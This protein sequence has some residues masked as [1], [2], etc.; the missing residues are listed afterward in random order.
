MMSFRGGQ[1]Y[2]K[3]ENYRGLAND[4]RKIADTLDEIQDVLDDETLSADEIEEKSDELLSKFLLQM[5]KLNS[6]IS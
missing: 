2:M 1:R 5:L 3:I 4:F 6:K